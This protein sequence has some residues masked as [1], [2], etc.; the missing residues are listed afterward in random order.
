[1]MDSS[2]R[3]KKYFDILMIPHSAKFLKHIFIKIGKILAKTRFLYKIYDGIL[4]IT[5]IV[6]KKG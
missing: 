3:I 6:K 4:V 1:M 5:R 2:I